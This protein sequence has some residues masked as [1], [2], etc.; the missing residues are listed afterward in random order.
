MLEADYLVVGAGAMGMAFVDE[1]ITQQPSARLIL[2]ER[3]G[4]P[5]GHWNDAYPF[6]S[7]HQPAAYYGVNSEKFGEGGGALATGAEVLGYF[8][9]VMRKLLRTGRLQFFP[10]CDY[11]GEGRFV[12]LVDGT[13][14]QVKVRKKVVDASYMKVEV[15]ATKPPAYEVAEDAELVPPNGLAGLEAPHEGYVIVGSGKTGM[16]ACLFLLD[17]G[18]EP[19][20]IRWIMPND[21]WLLDRDNVEPGAVIRRGQHLEVQCLAESRTLR[22]YYES[23]ERH[24]RLI[25]L[26][27]EV[28]P[29]KWRCATVNHRELERLRSIEHI[30][31]MGRVKRIERDQ[32]LLD[33]G[34]IQTGPGWLHVDCTA[35][36]L[37]KRPVLPVFDGDRITL[38]SVFMCQQV[39]SAALIAHVECKYANDERKNQLTRVV[40]HPEFPVDN[41]TASA[42]SMGNLVAWGTELRGWLR[43]SRLFILHHEPL[44]GLISMTFR[45]RKHIAQIEEAVS[46]ILADHRSRQQGSR[47]TTQ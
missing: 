24:G 32:V 18:I 28:W 14:H 40:P 21:A 29:T 16:D 30:V 8:D 1:I 5:G 34:T 33:E 36:G 3:R 47:K 12:S 38:Q 35:D 42:T 2:V 39:F 43:G 15:P 17:R 22:E 45:T 10:L 11:Q 26:D 27:P 44:M 37:A 31:R 25:R 46:A 9:R 7:L 23:L 41:V 4:K 6:V 19:G 13:Q 20:R